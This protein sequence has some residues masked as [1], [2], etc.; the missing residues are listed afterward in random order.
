MVQLR[1]DWS[2][3]FNEMS[4]EMNRI[5]DDFSSLRPPTFR[6]SR[7]T[8]EPAVD[9]Y[10]TA[11]SVVVVV[12]LA[13]LKEEDIEV[14]VQGNTLIIKGI[15]RDSITQGQRSYHQIE[16]RRGPFER[17]VALPVAVDPEQTSACYEN[18]LLEI[19]MTKLSE[20]NFDR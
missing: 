19:V 7:R 4:R 13:G 10:E 20:T 5:M 2:T 14:L 9:M 6:F 16:I 3:P 1:R 12:D 15:R 11:D 18:G 17:E 8:W